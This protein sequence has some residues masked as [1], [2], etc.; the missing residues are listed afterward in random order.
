MPAHSTE[1]ALLAE[2]LDSKA[3]ATFVQP[4]NAVVLKESGADAKLKKITLQHLD[5]HALVLLPEKGQ[6]HDHR[7]TP[8]F[9]CP[10]GWTHHKACD[11]VLFIKWKQQDYIVY[12][13]LKSNN[14][15]GC[16]QQIQAAEHFVD[17]IFNVLNWQ[18]QHVRHRRITRRVVFNT[19]KTTCQTINKSPINP[20]NAVHNYAIWQKVSDNCVLSPADF[21]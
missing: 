18:K 19:S 16:E 17:Y 11:A 10:E 4:N 2:L 1:T 6:T 21:C 14:P 12:I 9:G 3:K 8:I 20:R 7:Y 5:A 15:K 13:E